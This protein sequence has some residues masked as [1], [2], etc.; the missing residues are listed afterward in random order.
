MSEAPEREHVDVVPVPPVRTNVVWLILVVATCATT[1]WLS[2]NALTATVSTV[3][4]ILI[5][6]VKVR[7]VI[8]EFMGLRE[9]PIPWRTVGDIWLL[10][11]TGAILTLYLV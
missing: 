2:K 3:L 10:A 11:V 4:M 5:G 1:W 7:L 8:Q 9:A 6:A